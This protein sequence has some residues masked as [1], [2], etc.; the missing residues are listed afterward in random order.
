M[1]GDSNTNEDSTGSNP[2]PANT[3]VT[4]L[5]ENRSLGE[6]DDDEYV[7]GNVGWLFESSNDRSSD[8]KLVE[9]H[10]SEDRRLEPQR[11]GMTDTLEGNISIRLPDG[12]KLS[13]DSSKTITKA[14]EIDIR[15]TC[16]FGEKWLDQGTVR[17]E[18]TGAVYLK[19]RKIP[20]AVC[21]WETDEQY[22]L[23]MFRVNSARYGPESFTPAYR[24]VR[25]ERFQAIGL[26]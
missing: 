12:R 9:Y 25:D 2:D 4:W 19:T 16:M 14:F 7:N 1:S 22:E 23:V 5:A 21:A 8:E 3:I 18:E 26:F 6:W 20:T 15:L 17:D 24:R 11:H 10:V 13:W